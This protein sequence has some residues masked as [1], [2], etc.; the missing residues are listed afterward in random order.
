LNKATRFSTLSVGGSGNTETMMQTAG[1]MTGFPVRTGFARGFPEHDPWRFDSMRLVESGEADALLW[2]A[3]DAAEPPHWGSRVPLVAVTNA[4]Y[5]PSAAKVQIAI[6]QH[7]HDHDSVD[8]ARETQSLAW[9]KAS[10]KSDLPSA[11][12]VMDAIAASLSREAA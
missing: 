12:S 9:R 3:S 4:G 10:A 2:I 8:F 5:A 7:G 6:G 11:A 1:W